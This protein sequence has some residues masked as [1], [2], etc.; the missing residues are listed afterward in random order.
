VPLIGPP[1]TI[2][3]NLP[4]E[5]SKGGKRDSKS[6]LPSILKNKSRDSSFNDSSANHTDRATTKVIDPNS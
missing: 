6:Y 2:L 1:K 3:N 4:V 5:I